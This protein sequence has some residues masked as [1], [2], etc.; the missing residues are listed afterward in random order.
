MS[1]TKIECQACADGEELCNCNTRPDPHHT[2]GRLCL[3]KEQM[4]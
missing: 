4:R 2:S 3:R 1:A